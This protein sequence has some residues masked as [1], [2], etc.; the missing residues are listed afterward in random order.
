MFK[1]IKL[2]SGYEMPTLGLGTWKSEPNKVGEAVKYALLEAGYKH[3]DGA[4]I[5]LNEKEVGNAYQE[6]FSII[7][8]Q[9]IFLTSK[10]WNTKHHQ[11]DV[12]LACR[13]TLSDLQLDYLDL[14]LMHWGISFVPGDNDKPVDANGHALIDKTPIKETWLAMEQLVA[15]GLV[16]SIGVANFTV[17]QLDSLLSYAQIKPAVNQVEM[18][19]YLSQPELLKYCQKKAVTVTA[20]SPLGRLGVSSIDMPRLHEDPVVISLSQKYN[21]S[22]AQILLNWALV[23]GTVAIPKSVTPQRIKENLDSYYFTLIKED[24]ELL[25]SLNKNLRYVDPSSDWG[26]NYF[27]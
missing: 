10:L 6:V 17:S 22:V 21:K 9:E 23:R 2:N 27:T 12:E 8:R 14:Y 7:D 13:K 4:S 24:V 5:Y 20:Y 18:H 26:I 11:V 3:I 16:R 25:N 19:P 1:S 15:Q